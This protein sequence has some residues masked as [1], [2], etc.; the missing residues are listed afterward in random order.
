M[1]RAK[2]YQEEQAKLAQQQQ[3]NIKQLQPPMLVTVQHAGQLSQHSS[4]STDEITS[5]T[6]PK[7]VSNGSCQQRFLHSPHS[8]TV[9]KTQLGGLLSFHQSVSYS[10][11]S[12]VPES[13]QSA[14]VMS[15]NAQNSV[16]LMEDEQ[17]AM[18]KAKVTSMPRISRGYNKR[19][20]K[21]MPQMPHS[22]V[23]LP[24]DE[25]SSQGRRSQSGRSSFVSASSP[26]RSSASRSPRS[27][28][29]KT[30]KKGYFFESKSRGSKKLAKIIGK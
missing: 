27:P 25:H 28:G 12:S 2:R 21:E 7:S 23:A 15:H 3:Q 18:A 16:E 29:T 6:S 13:V 17:V 22:A 11:A 26:K 24:M 1:L 30:K 14:L 8:S 20:Y 10:T 5:K 4:A 9:P 19:K